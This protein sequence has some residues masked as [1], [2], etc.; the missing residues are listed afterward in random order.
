[1]LKDHRLHMPATAFIAYS[2]DRSLSLL[3]GKGIARV[4]LSNYLRTGLRLTSAGFY[5]DPPDYIDRPFIDQY[6]PADREFAFGRETLDCYQLP[7]LMDRYA[8][9]RISCATSNSDFVAYFGGAPSDLPTFY[10]IL[11]SANK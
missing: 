3:L 7:P 6:H 4:G 1:M 11:T 5:V 8:D 9:T 10:E 2:D